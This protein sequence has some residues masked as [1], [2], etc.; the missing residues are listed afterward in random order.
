MTNWRAKSSLLWAVCLGQSISV[1]W[2]LVQAL[3]GVYK[4]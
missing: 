1:D 2:D 4:E 3:V